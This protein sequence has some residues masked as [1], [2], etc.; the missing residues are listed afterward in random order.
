MSYDHNFTTENILR[1]KEQEVRAR[2]ERLGY[3]LKLARSEM[4]VL[5][6]LK[7]RDK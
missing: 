3:E 5:Q 6:E 7:K 2:I 1:E 4:G